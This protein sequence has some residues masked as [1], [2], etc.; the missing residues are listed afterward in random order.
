MYRV[1]YLPMLLPDMGRYA[2]WTGSY[3][4]PPCSTP[5]LAKLVPRHMK[6]HQYHSWHGLTRNPDAQPAKPIKSRPIP[7]AWP[8]GE[9]YGGSA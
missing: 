2:Y 4:C 5:T 1:R 6:A 9:N 8:W 3:W 7:T